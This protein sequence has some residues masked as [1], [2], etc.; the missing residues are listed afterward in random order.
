MEIAL[1]GFTMLKT[2]AMTARYTNI[3]DISPLTREIGKMKLL[4][5]F[6]LR[7]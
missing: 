7:L 1:S 5:H 6:D 3:S 4:E 2:V